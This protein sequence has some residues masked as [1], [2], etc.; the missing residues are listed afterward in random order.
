MLVHFLVS[1]LSLQ[2]CCSINQDLSSS[3]LVR[4]LCFVLTVANLER[5]VAGEAAG[6]IAPFL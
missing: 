2:G 4:C 6:F 5:F 1:V 3:G